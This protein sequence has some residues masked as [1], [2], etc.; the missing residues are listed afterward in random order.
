MIVAPLPA[1]PTEPVMLHVAARRFK[2]NVFETPAA[3]A[4]KTAV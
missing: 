3:V 4:V 1:A 2:E